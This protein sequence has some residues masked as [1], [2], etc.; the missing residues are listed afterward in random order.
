MDLA[1]TLPRGSGLIYRH[2]GAPNRHHIAARLSKI[3]KRRHLKLLIGNDPKLALEIGADGVHWPEMRFTEAKYWQNRFAIMTCAAHSRQTLSRLQREPID[4]ALVSAIF[5]SN[6]PSAS[7]PLGVSTLRQLCTQS[8]IPLYA[9]GG[10]NI[11]NMGKIS[12]YSGISGIEGI[13]A[14][15]QKQART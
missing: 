3:T 14:V 8:T 9:L 1:H 4:A 12:K 10:V 7:A 6:S 2:F 5:P 13:Q 11:Q 15:L